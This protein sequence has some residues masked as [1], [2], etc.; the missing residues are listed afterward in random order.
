MIKDAASFSINVS[1]SYSFAVCTPDEFSRGRF[2][3]CDAEPIV[4]NHVQETESPATQHA[5]HEIPT[6]FTPLLQ[7]YACLVYWISIREKSGFSLFHKYSKIFNSYRSK[8]GLVFPLGLLT[9]EDKYLSDGNFKE[10]NK[11]L[12]C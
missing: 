11:V 5:P 1:L 10:E 7:L 8:A 12:G 3:T 4:V 6:P 9:G 2:R